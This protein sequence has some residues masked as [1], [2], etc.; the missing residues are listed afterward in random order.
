MSYG[1]IRMKRVNALALAFAV[2]AA[3]ACASGGGTTGAPAAGDT[4]ARPSDNSYTQ[5]ATVHLAQAAMLS[6]PEAES[7]YELALQDALSSIEEEPGNPRG[8]LVAGQ[9]AVGVGDW[10]QADSMFDRAEDLYP[11]YADQ[12]VSEREAGW[13]AAYNLGAEV[14]NAGDL[15]AAAEYF[16]GADML[17][18]GRAEALMALG[19]LYT[20]LGRTEDA[21]Q[22]Y[23]GALE[24]LSGPIPEGIDEEQVA[25]WEEDRRIAAINA[26][27]LVAETGD[28]ARAAEML[29]DFLAENAGDIDSATELQAITARAGFLA[30]AGQAQEAA[31]IYDELLARTDLSSADYFQIGVGFFNTGDY[32]QAADAF[33]RSAEMNPHSRDALLNMVQSLFSQA[34]ELEEEP[35]SAAGAEEL[36]GIYDRIIET[37]DR[38][39]EFDPLNRNLLSFLLHAYRAKTEMAERAEAERLRQAT[40]DLFRRYQEQTYE[41]S[42]ITLTTQGGGQVG[43]SGMLTNLTGQAGESVQL[44]FSILGEAGQT[45]E[46]STVN[47]SAPAQGEAAE[48]S[49]TVPIPDGSFAG[50]SYELV[51]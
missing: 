46:T 20:R 27:Q 18:Q 30:Q 15:E 8:Y 19:S 10:V 29:G 5:S 40:Q 24:I 44:R 35:E 7:H 17:Y 34:L 38:V 14:L 31:A 2:G 48:F 1:G 36:A 25:Q 4:G 37:A 21:A 12:L 11:P 51:R 9:A 32:A 41:V 50:W 3:T 23:L 39:R 45:I 43:I 28:Y 42:G 47:V 26:S 16:E 22:A 13:V 49:T 33:E 6:G